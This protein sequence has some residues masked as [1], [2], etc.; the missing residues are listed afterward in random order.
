MSPESVTFWLLESFSIQHYIILPLGLLGYSNARCCRT[1]TPGVQV[2]PGPILGTNINSMATMD[3]DGLSPLG[4][5][6]LSLPPAAM[7]PTPQ[8]SLA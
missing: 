8:S 1:S 7:D 2:P 5:L 3:L 4:P 6:V